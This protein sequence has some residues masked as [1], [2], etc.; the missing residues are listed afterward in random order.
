M[1]VFRAHKGKKGRGSRRAR[2]HSHLNPPQLSSRHPSRHTV[3]KKCR[4]VPDERK[5]VKYY[6]VGLGWRRA[7]K[8]LFLSL[9]FHLFYV[10][11]LPPGRSILGRAC[12]SGA[13][14]NSEAVLCLHFPKHFW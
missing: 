10:F 9:I 2:E 8:C 13:L 6:D 5:F 12:R 3:E 4:S 11:L 1:I 7:H 14:P